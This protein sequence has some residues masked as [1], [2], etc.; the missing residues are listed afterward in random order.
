MTV[1][2]ACLLWAALLASAAALAQPV[3]QPTTEPVTQPA[4][5]PAS[6]PTTTQAAKEKDRFL[7][8]TN[9]RVHTVT[10]PVLERATVLS[11]NGVITAL[12]PDVAL[13]PG[14]EV[15]DATGLDVYPGL[16]AAVA[17]GIHG[18]TNP[19]DTTNVY[20][21][22]MLIALAGGITTALAGN[23]VAK[24]TFGSTRTC[25]SSRTRT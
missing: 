25:W 7:A 2:R 5:Q 20:S 21:L 12:G 10:G 14:C 16:I 19:Q 8:V 4:S 1:L 18:A 11:K 3:S 13:P 15:V 6:A 24:L 9:G 23:D 22:N 17:S